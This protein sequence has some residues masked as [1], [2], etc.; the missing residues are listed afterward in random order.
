[1]SSSNQE[2]HLIFFVHGMGVHGKGWSKKAQKTLADAYNRLAPDGT[3]FSDQ[4]DCCEIFYD[5]IIEKWRKNNAKNLD[6]ALNTLTLEGADSGV[7]RTIRHIG[8]TTSNDNFLNTHI[9]DVA[10]YR[11]INQF[12]ELIRLR[13]AKK[14]VTEVQKKDRAFKREW[15]IVGHSLGTIVVHDTLQRMFAPGSSRGQVGVD[16]LDPANHGPKV[17]LMVANV[18]RVLSN[19][20][21][22]YHSFVRPHNDP[23]QGAVDYYL[24]SRHEMDPIASLIP[25]TPNQETWLDSITRAK[26]HKRYQEKELVLPWDDVT[27][28]NIHALSHYFQHPGLYVLFFRAMIG[29]RDLIMDFELEAALAKYRQATLKGQVKKLQQQLNPIASGNIDGLGGFLK[30]IKAFGKI[31]E[32][33]Y[34]I[35]LSQKGGES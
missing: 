32:Q 14:I 34:H 10:F 7:L 1:M 8:S 35:D 20:F 28:I 19:D 22:V 21:D 4:F 5:D 25:F 2:K 30:S 24:T 33:S 23:H 6:A 15:S 31:L 9:L 12:Q 29:D 11:F 18:C 13:V 3:K 16:R 26:P 17:C 27:A